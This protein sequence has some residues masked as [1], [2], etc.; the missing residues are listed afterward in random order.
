MKGMRKFFADSGGAECL[1]LSYYSPDVDAKWIVDVEGPESLQVIYQRKSIGI[2]YDPETG[3]PKENPD[4]DFW[5]YLSPQDARVIG[6]VLLAYAAAN[7]E[8][9]E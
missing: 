8:A 5:L 1:S 2:T 4:E 7:G 6:S 3:G 9:V